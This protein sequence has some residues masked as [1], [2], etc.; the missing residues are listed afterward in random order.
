M[1]F[2]TTYSGEV[3]LLKYMLNFAP[4]DNKV[5][6]LFTNN[7]TP[8]QSDVLSNYTESVAAGYAASTLTGTAWTISTV[9]GTSSAQYAQQTFSFSA[10]ETLYGYY[11]TDNA[12]T[13]VIWAE[14]FAA[15]PFTMPVSGGVVDITPVI[16]LL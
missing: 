5:L 3:S 9:A 6:H 16:T 11:I 4:A 15:A 14:R 10:A 13:Q 12:A 2:I 1:A 8:A 7:Q